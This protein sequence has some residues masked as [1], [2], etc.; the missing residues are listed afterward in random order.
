VRG[1][2][3]LVKD[4]CAGTLTKVMKGKVT[5]RDLTLRKNRTLK[6]GQS[7]F[8]RAPKRK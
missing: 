1:T 5:V 6:T 8:A 2:Q 4:T 3:Y 7:Y